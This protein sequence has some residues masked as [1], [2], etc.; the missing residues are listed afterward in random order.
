MKKNIVIVFVFF[1]IWSCVEKE[2]TI[3]ENV[4]KQNEMTS[5]LTDFHIA[6]SAVNDKIRID[7]SLYTMN[8]YLIYIL[9]EHKTQ[10][11]DF[12]RSLKFYSDH[13]GMLKLVY[14][15]VITNLSRM[16]ARDE[17]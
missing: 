12:T 7:S 9:K 11:K 15:S 8:D 6:Q 14:D 3:P 4:L 13:P 16:E 10:K 17:K 2:I 5:I 1:F